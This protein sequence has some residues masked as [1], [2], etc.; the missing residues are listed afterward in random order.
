MSEQQT[1]EPGTIVTWE[2]PLGRR[3]AIRRN[4][5]WHTDT[6][7]PEASDEWISER[8]VEIL[9]PLQ[10][11][12]KRKYEE[13]VSSLEVKEARW[14]RTRAS[15]EDERDD[16]DAKYQQLLPKV[17]ELENKLHL[18]ELAAKDI[19]RLKDAEI[20]K[21]KALLKEDPAPTAAS[22]FDKLD[23]IR[24]TLVK[25]DEFLSRLLEK[26]DR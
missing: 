21:L 25:T 22:V 16:R 19:E 1:Y 8:Q 4:D 9:D 10:L 18:A 7:L 23:S 5:G 6:G 12:W 20:A 26:E 3:V 13:S 2:G 24:D 11:P 17:R 14:A 15:I